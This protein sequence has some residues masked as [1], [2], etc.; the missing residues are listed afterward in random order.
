MITPTLPSVYIPHGGG[1]CFFMDW[2]GDPHL[3][4]EMGQFLRG[5]GA[6]LPARPK[7]IVVVSA[8][9]E[10]DAFSLTGSAQPPLFFD[11][12]GFP[13]HTYELKYPAPGDPALAGRIATLLGDAGLPARIDPQR[14]FDHG[15]FVPLLLIYPEADIPVVQLS[16]KAGLDPAIH[17]AAGKALASLRE[18]GVLLL[19]SGM[20]FHNMQGF[21]RGGFDLPSRQFD[22]WLAAAAAAPQAEREALLREWDKAPGARA[23]HPREEH[24]LPLMVIAGAGGNVP[25]RKVFEGDIKGSTI[26]A[27][28]FG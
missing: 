26:S 3:W 23:S 15:M 13:P 8:H 25:G 20:S 17:L 11:Y 19:G 21:F 9:W 14:G 6:M 24:L 16:L 7:A 10:E 12:Y 4:D 28:S 27:F 22:A 18:E 2:P 5:L 1:P